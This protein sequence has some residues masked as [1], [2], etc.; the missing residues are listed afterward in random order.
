VGGLLC[1]ELKKIQPELELF[2]LGGDR[3][4]RSGVKVLYHINRHIPFMRSVEKSLLRETEANKPA[5]AILIDYPGFNLRIARKLKARGIP[6]LYYVSPQ[7]WAWGK[8]R[9]RKIKNLIDKMIVV[10]EFEKELYSDAGMEV[11]W[12]GHPL[13]DIVTPP[14][15]KSDFYKKAG[16]AE[17]RRYIGLL[18][19]SRLQEVR[20]ILPMMREAIE[21]LRSAGMD[22]EAIVGGVDGVDESVYGEIVGKDFRVLRNLTYDIMANADLNLVASGTATL[23]CAILGKPLFVLYKT[24]ALTYLIAKNLVKIPNIGLVNVVAGSR[25]APEFVQS[26]CNPDK[27]AAEIS[28]YFSD[29]AFR[30]QISQDLKSVRAKL[31]E[32]GASRKSAESVLRMLSDTRN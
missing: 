26:N 20:R 25:I 12:Y 18:P 30:E 6:V 2:G 17:D 31:G 28:R 13:L 11:E 3:M 32:T 19:G 16:L 9:I 22:L 14:L 10:F 27:I 15:G 24:S 7:V 5:L 21:K 29:S 8:K 23:E 4:N 1:G